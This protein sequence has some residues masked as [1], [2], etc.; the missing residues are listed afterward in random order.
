MRQVTGGGGVRLAVVEGGNPAGPPILFIHGYSQAALCWTRQFTGPLARDFRLV[1]FDLRGHGHSEKPAEPE[2]YQ[3]ADLWAEDVAAVIAAL[4]LERPVL[5]GWSF[6]GRILGSVARRYG[7]AELGG[8]VFAGCISKSGPAAA[9]F[10]GSATVFRDAM[11]S[12]DMAIAAEATLNFVRGCTAQPL[13]PDL[14]R[15]M[16]LANGM[17]PP[18]VRRGMTGWRVDHDD[19]LPTLKVPA[20]VIHGVQDQVLLPAAGEAI[21]ALLPGAEL[22]LYEASGHAPFLEEPAR[23]DADLAA[24]MRRVWGG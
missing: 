5:V 4:G 20:L 14:L 6:A 13:P 16:D 8:L 9:P 10:R 24:F 22:R 18:W 11:T 2:A 19:L 15:L 23:F 21:A 17:T 1:A 12:E 7:T 3:S